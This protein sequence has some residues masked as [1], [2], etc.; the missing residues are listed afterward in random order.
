[1]FDLC[2]GT[3]KGATQQWV[4]RYLYEQWNSKPARVR[5]IRGKAELISGMDI[6]RAL[7]IAFRFGGDQSNVGRREWGT[8]TFNGKRHWVFPLVPT[9]S[10]RAKLKEYFGQL[11]NWKIVVFRAQGDFGENL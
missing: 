8:V 4:P 5:L 2:L 3:T 1:M 7:D 9:G 11:Q 6:G 10:A